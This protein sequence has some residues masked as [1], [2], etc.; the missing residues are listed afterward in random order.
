MSLNE[1]ALESLLDEMAGKKRA[2][3][4]NAAPRSPLAPPP[5]PQGAPPPPPPASDK[6][7][8]AQKGKGGKKRKMKVDGVGLMEGLELWDEAEG[9][10]EREEDEGA[11]WRG[12]PDPRYGKDDSAA[13]TREPVLTG[14]DALVRGIDLMII[15]S[16]LL[17]LQE[18]SRLH[19]T[20]PRREIERYQAVLRLRETLAEKAPRVAGYASPRSHDDDPQTHGPHPPS[21]SSLCSSG[22]CW[23]TGSGRASSRRI[24]PD[25]S[26]SSSRR[27]SRAGRGSRS[28]RPLPGVAGACAWPGRWSRGCVTSRTHKLM[29]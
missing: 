25:R 23:S 21:G 2:K 26:S 7:K 10:E 8:G 27:F 9:E 4:A 15:A 1:A 24:L 12:M 3:P 13:V 28:S 14:E 19:V 17:L 18:S 20:C 5:T 11:A 6:G 16:V 22:H 29:E